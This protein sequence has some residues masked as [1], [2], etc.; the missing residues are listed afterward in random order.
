MKRQVIGQIND[1]DSD[2]ELKK[3]NKLERLMSLLHANSKNNYDLTP[4]EIWSWKKLL[5]PI[6]PLTTE[7]KLEIAMREK[8]K[9]KLKIESLQSIGKV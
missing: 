4:E 3:E 8:A 2:L 1:D 7:E 5:L 6:K 9:N